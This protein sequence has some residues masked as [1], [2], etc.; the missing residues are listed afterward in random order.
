MR[1]VL[2][3]AKEAVSQGYNVRLATSAGFLEHPFY[4]TLQ[5][6]CKDSVRLVALPGNN[7]SRP[8][9]G[10]GGYRMHYYKMFA[11]CY[12]QL[13][14]HERPDYV[15]IPYLDYCV[16]AAGLLGSP[17]GAARWGGI[18]INPIFH[19]NEMGIR[20][21]R[22]RWQWIKKKLF[23]RLLRDKALR[24][25][26]TLDRL[27]VR[28]MHE[29]K[30][31]LAKSL[32][33]IPEPVELRGSQSRDSARRAL[34]IPGD[35]TVV[36]VYGALDGSKGLDALLRSLQADG[37]REEV[38]VLVAGRQDPDIRVLLAS[39]QAK[40]LR[41]A[42]RIHERN[43]FLYDEGEQ[44]VFSASDI[45]WVGYRRQYISSAVLIQAAM[46]GLPIVACDE[47]LIGWLTRKHEL[48]LTVDIGDERAVATAISE[49]ARNEELSKKFRENGRRFYTQHTVDQ[50]S[51]A[52]GREL[53]LNFPVHA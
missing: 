43:D 33:F 48:G 3:I 24:R 7:E 12:G 16:H 23:F 45:V 18:I 32:C 1:Y 5:R 10:L 21:P 26:F 46:A 9:E 22:S 47:G 31:G 11:E 51:R 19:L 6:E 14:Q 52:I 28:Y 41:D 2:W 29:N 15:F 40:A 53:L 35:A 27:L 37:V 36:L 39:S 30:P 44:E 20:V 42:G 50:F 13:L 4:F 38:S 49:L 17:F 8:V 34:G 25:V